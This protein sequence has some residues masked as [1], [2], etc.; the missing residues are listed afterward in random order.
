M[1]KFHEF[2]NKLNWSVKIWGSC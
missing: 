1:E 2:H